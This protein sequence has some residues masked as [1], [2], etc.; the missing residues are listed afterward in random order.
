MKPPR[1]PDII[2]DLGEWL[3]PIAEVAAVAAVLTVIGFG[4]LWLIQSIGQLAP[5]L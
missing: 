5:I 1:K 2:L 3:R 4:G